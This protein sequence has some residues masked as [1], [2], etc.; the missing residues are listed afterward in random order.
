[1]WRGLL[2]VVPGLGAHPMAAE[3]VAKFDVFYFSSLYF[4]E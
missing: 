2:L 3:S 4:S 1:V